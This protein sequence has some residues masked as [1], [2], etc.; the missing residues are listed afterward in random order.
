MRATE[1]IDAMQTLSVNPYRFLIAPRLTAAVITLPLLTVVA[2]IIGVAGGWLVA[3]A[4]LKFNST[5]YIRN[6]WN[7]LQSWD[8]V[9]G[10]IKAAAFGFFIAL[11]GCYNG[12]E[13]DGGAA[14][15][16]RATT[17]AVV[18]AFV[19]ILLSD[20]LITVLAFG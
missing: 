2:D 3:V 16:G 12:F 14:G 9:S 17:N 18:S 10:L 8:I 19:L 7:F 13:A 20:L 6:T 11:M 15:V 4:S 1:Q 5:V